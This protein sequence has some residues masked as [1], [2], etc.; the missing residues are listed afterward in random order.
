MGATGIIDIGLKVACVPRYFLKKYLGTCINMQVSNSA[1]PR[2]KDR[3]SQAGV[4][5]RQMAGRNP[6]KSP[7]NIPELL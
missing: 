2:T 7:T 5:Q 3:G 4:M 6:Q 1:G